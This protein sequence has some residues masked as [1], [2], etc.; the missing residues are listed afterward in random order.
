MI[1]A[2]RTALAVALWTGWMGWVALAAGA[3]TPPSASLQ[4]VVYAVAVNGA[5]VSEGALLMQTPAR[6]LYARA[7]DLRAWRINM[8]GGIAPVLRASVPYIALR[9]IPGLRVSFD[10]ATQTLLLQAGPTALRGSDILLTEPARLSV[11]R[12]VGAYANYALTQSGGSYGATAAGEMQSGVAA[13]GGIFKNDIAWTP[14][15]FSRLQTAWE[16]DDAQRM[17]TIVVGDSTTTDTRLGT[18][19]RFA[20]VRWASDFTEQPQFATYPGLAIRG[21]ASVPSQL[22]IYVND[23]L[24]QQR[25]VPA[26]PY[27][28][29]DLPVFDG[30]GTVAVRAADALGGSA[31]FNVP[32]YVSNTLLKP[33]LAS[34]SY[35]AGFLDENS[36]YGPFFVDA[37]RRWG[38]SN[39][40]TA[41]AMAQF[42]A[43]NAIA[44]ADVDWLAGRAGVLSLATATSHGPA[45]TGTLWDAGYDYTGRRLTFGG[46]LRVASSAYASLD[47]TALA[48]GHEVN[49][50][51]SVR[52]TRTTSAQFSI[53]RDAT[54]AGPV[55]LATAGIAGTAAGIPY[56]LTAYKTVGA[57]ADAFGLTAALSLPVGRRATLSPRIGSGG[58]STQSQLEYAGFT[59]D[60]ASAVNWDVAA[61]MTRGATST[62]R[63]SAS[64]SHGELDVDATSTAGAWAYTASVQ[65]GIALVGGTVASTRLITGA[66]GLVRV[67]GFA[68]VDVYVNDRYAGK[69]D[70][71][72]ELLTADLVPF[73]ENEV[74]ID[75]SRLAASVHVDAL[76]H[77]VVPTALGGT[78]IAFS[79][80]AQTEAR[81]TLRTR[82]GEPLRAGTLVRQVGG[83][84]AWPI[85]LG[86]HVDLIGISPG[87]LTLRS[88]TAAETCTIELVI[89][90]ATRIVNLP[91]ARCF[92]P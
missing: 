79:A 65:G 44:G 32:Y 55:S 25:S 52:I 48:I 77:T 10:A 36:S 45:G 64:N 6:D 80:R 72:G 11:A 33:G 84:A 20:G 26:G 89:P 50:H 40:L 38:I 14:G 5:R 51:A 70:A 85:G 7:D 69:T 56:S 49:L 42:G 81:L 87:P 23:V 22:D 62:A 24:A 71:R 34:F 12:P 13:F 41:G 27:T 17:R 43:G 82:D 90:A 29:R 91:D 4:P 46:E 2:L 68:G 88:D 28:L 37:S 74:R 59:A 53:A 9:A 8:P 19:I 39:T 63:L 61:G 3:A 83:N 16:H 15:Y 21:A 66:Y 86:G 18:A 54:I 78:T 57:S 58:N 1:G 67:P 47:P 60:G 73:V 31:Q 76:M 75:P 35:S 30:S 92:Q